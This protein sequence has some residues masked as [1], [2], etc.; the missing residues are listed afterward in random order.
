MHWNF[1]FA[2]LVGISIEMMSSV[3]GLKIRAITAGNKK[4]KSIIK[5]KK[6]SMIK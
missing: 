2:S 1:A 3:V 4:Q 5:E 6:K